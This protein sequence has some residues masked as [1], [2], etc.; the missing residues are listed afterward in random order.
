MCGNKTNSGLS[1]DAET[2][3]LKLNLNPDYYNI[4]VSNQLSPVLEL[5]GVSSG[6]GLS[7]DATTKMSRFSVNSNQNFINPTLLIRSNANGGIE[8][9]NTTELSIKLADTS[10]SS[11]SFELQVSTTYKSESQD[12]KTDTQIFKTQGTKPIF[13]PFP[14]FRFPTF[15]FRV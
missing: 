4:N 6:Q 2:K 10:L 5:K 15:L 13:S 12:L 14:T 1:I 11:S 8:T 3:L 9:I 7:E